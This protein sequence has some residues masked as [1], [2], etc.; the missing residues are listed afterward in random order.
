MNIYICVC[1]H[2]IPS[3]AHAKRVWHHCK[4]VSAKCTWKG[5]NFTIIYFTK[6]FISGRPSTHQTWKF[7]KT[8]EIAE[9]NRT[10]KCQVG[11]RPWG[12]LTPPWELMA[13][14]FAGRKTSWW[15]EVETQ[16]TVQ[17][18]AI[19]KHPFFSSNCI[20]YCLFMFVLLS[21]DQGDIAQNLASLSH[22]L[23]VNRDINALSQDPYCQ[24]VSRAWLKMRRISFALHDFYWTKHRIFLG[25]AE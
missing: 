20:R 22:P 7:P 15:K 13:D 12:E 3:P 10:S 8:F 14:E 6:K 16:T 21:M 17:K 18:V 25:I 19:L 4:A 23:K 11:W 5:T 2:S 24:F 9:V 1:I